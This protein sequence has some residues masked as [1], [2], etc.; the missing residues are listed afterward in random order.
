MNSSKIKTRFYIYALA[1]LPVMLLLGTGII[2]LNYHTGTPK[3]T[4]IMGFNG[5]DW[6]SFHKVISVITTPLI[7]LHLFVKTDW[8]KR[9]FTF[10][11]KG[12]F[13]KSNIIL[14]IVFLLCFLTA[15]G[16]WLIF[17]GTDIASSL[18]GVH[19]KFGLL[20][21]VMFGIHIWNYRKQIINQF[22]KI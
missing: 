6:L 4:F 14:F 3:E 19:N 2:M 22:K 21:I 7:L 15:I 18:R 9:L 5:Y 13:K 1:F 8:V 16:S 20:L 10:K 11:V 12:A 17:D